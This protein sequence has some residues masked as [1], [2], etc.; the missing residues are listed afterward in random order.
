M[1]RTGIDPTEHSLPLAE[2]IKNYGKLTIAVSGGVDSMTLGSFAH[3]LLGRQQ[4]KL[5]H[6]LSPAV[7]KAATLRVETQAEAEGWDIRMVDAGEFEDEQYRA[8]PFNR[9]FFCKTNLYQTLSGLSSGILVSGTNADDLQDFRP[10]LEAAQ[11]HQVRH[12]YVEAGFNKDDV[13]A[14]ASELGLPQLSRLPSSPCLSSRVETG[15]RIERADLEA[16]DSVESWIQSEFTP[17]TVRCRV[18]EEGIMIQMDP[19]TLS[20]LDLEDQKKTE[21]RVL[22]CFQH[23]PSTKVRFSAYQRGSAFKIPELQT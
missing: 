22:E 7:P 14:L 11:N 10:G 16:I 3:R 8:N 9:C 20:G 2:I 1:E 21:E 4:V 5:V 15:I 13:R 19:L 18:L 12:P 23:R 17:K 6:A